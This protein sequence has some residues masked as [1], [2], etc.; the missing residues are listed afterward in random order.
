MNLLQLRD[1]L[2]ELKV[3]QTAE[4]P[5]LE[6]QQRSFALPP[7]FK[8]NPNYQL[9]HARYHRIGN[10]GGAQNVTKPL[11]D[12]EIQGLFVKA[13]WNDK[14]NHYSVKP[15]HSGSTLGHAQGIHLGGPDGVR[16]EINE[17]G[18]Q[19]ALATGHKNPHS[20]PMGIVQ[21]TGITDDDVPPEAV[22]LA[23]SAR[24]GHY[25]KLDTDHNGRPV[26]G[27]RVDK[28]KAVYMLPPTE[29]ARTAWEEAKKAA[30]EGG[31]NPV[32][33]QGKNK[34]PKGRVYGVLYGDENKPEGKAEGRSF[35]AKTEKKHPHGNL[36]LVERERYNPHTG[37]GQMWHYYVRER[38]PKPVKELVQA[39]HGLVTVHDLLAAHQPEYAT[40]LPYDQGRGPGRLAVT[41]HH[42]LDVA[43]EAYRNGW[44]NGKLAGHF[45]KHGHELDWDAV[46]DNLRGTTD[47]LLGVAMQFAAA[48]AYSSDITDSLARTQAARQDAPSSAM[49]RYGAVPSELAVQHSLVPLIKPFQQQL[50]PELN[51]RLKAAGAVQG[52]VG[53]SP[54]YRT[55]VGM[56]LAVP[57]GS[58]LLPD[59]ATTGVLA[60][61][62]LGTLEGGVLRTRQVAAS[63]VYAFAP[64][65]APALRQQRDRGTMSNLVVTV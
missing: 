9:D 56:N 32:K 22:P 8:G 19:R 46:H 10:L 6:L 42:M 36:S 20:F 16:F 18:R 37:E 17:S 43:A 60:G 40:T 23:Y 65:Q 24:I 45:A 49:E 62:H 47:D 14:N 12:N 52:R 25:F 44:D 7:D 13:H 30:V 27:D 11:G 61:L 48:G 33:W 4:Q 41:P 51:A 31:E 28:A 39:N 5:E 63:T 54:S 35:A 1:L 59:G 29:K 3:L 21:R 58:P 15:P 57:A 2:D 38:V 53:N 26:P 34:P 55:N 50:P 64:D